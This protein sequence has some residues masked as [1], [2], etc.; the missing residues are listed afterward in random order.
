M[1]RPSFER[2]ERKAA[3][4]CSNN[5]HPTDGVTD[6]VRDL[7]RTGLQLRRAMYKMSDRVVDIDVKCYLFPIL[8]ASELTVAITNDAFRIR[9]L[10]TFYSFFLSFILSYLFIYLFICAYSI[11]RS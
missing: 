9:Q 11:L 1:V 6:T 4:F 7:G 2:V 3:R 5:Y 8:V 10:R